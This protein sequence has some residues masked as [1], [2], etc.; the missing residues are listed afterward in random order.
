MRDEN[1]KAGTNCMEFRVSKYA[2]A[3][4]QNNVFQ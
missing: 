2:L 1:D 4:A 3:H